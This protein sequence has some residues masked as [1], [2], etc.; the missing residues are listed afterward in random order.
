MM[1]LD[2]YADP[3]GDGGGGTGTGGADPN[4]EVYP[5][6]TTSDGRHLIPVGT[7][8]WD[9]ILKI[10]REVTSPLPRTALTV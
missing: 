2:P 1:Y 4:G 8:W 7:G 6:G 3:Y 5:D 9:P 10:W